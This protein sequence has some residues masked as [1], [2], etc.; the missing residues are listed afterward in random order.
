MIIDVVQCP[1]WT[2]HYFYSRGAGSYQQNT[3]Q[4]HKTP[5]WREQKKWWPP[6][7]IQKSDDPPHM[8]LSW[9]HNVPNN[10]TNSIIEISLANG[11]SVHLGW[12]VNR[13]GF[14][15]KLISHGQNMFHL[16]HFEQI[17]PLKKILRGYSTPGPYFWRP[18]AFSQKIKQLWKKKSY[19]SGQKCSKEL[20][21]HKF[22][23]SRN[24]C[25]M[26]DAS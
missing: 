22:Y 21:K 24:H 17:C 15:F 18:C 23:I 1:L 4:K 13:E 20:K 25:L 9:S 19:G 16:T 2:V 11:S 26:R 8:P 6:S 14:N 5:L 10:N 7:D 12:G 3:S